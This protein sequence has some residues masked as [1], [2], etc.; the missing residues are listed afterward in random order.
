MVGRYR[1]LLIGNSTYPADEHNLQ[2]L[3]GPIKDIV[4]VSRALI[5][6][7]T[8]LF[9]D[10]DVT[11]LPETTSTRAIRALGKFFAGAGRDDVLLMYFSGHGKLDQTGRLHLCMQ[12]TETSDLLSTA[13]SNV[14]INEF[15]DA[16]RAR[17]IVLILDCCYAGAFR[18]SDLGEA[19]AG[20]GRYVLSSCRGTQLAND[21]TVDNGTS[22][23]TQHLVDGLLTATDSD[24]DGYVSFS[25]IYAYVDRRLREAGK[26]IPARRVDGDGDLRLARRPGRTAV[27][28]T[29]AQMAQVGPIP[30]TAAGR[31]PLAASA[32]PAPPEGPGAPSAVAEDPSPPERIRAGRAAATEGEPALDGVAGAG[33]ITEVEPAPEGVDGAGRATEGPPPERIRADGPPPAGDGGSAREGVGGP[34]PAGEGSPP[35]GSARV[36]GLRVRWTR[37]RVVAVVLVVVAAGAAAAAALLVPGAVGDRSTPGSGTYTATGPWRLR[38][39]P[40][41]YGNGCTVTLTNDSSGEPVTTLSSSSFYSVARFQVSDAGSFHWRTNDNRCLVTPFAGTGEATL[42]LLQQDN[43]DTDAIKAPSGKLAIHIVDNEGGNCTV[44]LFDAANGQALDISRWE[45]GKGDFTLDPS[46][47]ASVYVSDDNCVIRVAAQA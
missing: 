44:R 31:D 18:G 12:D 8:G 42:P 35:P 13:V 11:L 39:D 38:L 26:Q 37:R 5:D 4:A 25:D 30:D 17:N 15:A 19:V 1:A 9:A 36:R 47:R 41:V 40:T 28:A 20:P 32:A 10:A 16:S 29:P 3:R 7:D 6:T 27:P 24:E 14:R 45:P 23:F 46:G 2:P 33:P 21:A 22:F 43:G 34:A